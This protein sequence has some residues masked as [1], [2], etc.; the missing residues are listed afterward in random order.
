MVGS[1]M[2]FG[3]ER[4]PVLVD[5]LI[6]SSYNKDKKGL[7]MNTTITLKV[8]DQTRE[9]ILRLVSLRNKPIEEL[10]SDII[11]E[12]YE[13]EFVPILYADRR[14]FWKQVDKSGGPDA[15]WPWLGCTNHQD[16]NGYGVGRYQKKTNHSHRI[17]YLLETGKILNR[18]TVIRHKC[19]NKLCCNPK[20]LEEGTH[21]DN[22]ADWQTRLIDQKGE[23]N[24]YAKLT[25]KQVSKI[26]QDAFEGKTLKSIADNL[27]VS[28]GTVSLIVSGRTWQ[29][30]YDPALK[31]PFKTGNRNGVYKKFTDEQIRIIRSDF[32]NKIA[33]MG[34]LAKEYKVTRGVINRI[35]RRE[36][37]REVL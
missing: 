7:N 36:T 10:L 23:H 18:M 27:G 2:Q 26:R 11:C 25:E 24:F 21:A 35:I 19:D 4:M 12:K 32:E 15:C 30:S 20:H 5:C 37:Y 8:D 28:G 1:M 9:Y 29:H 16:A 31:P 6:R 22:I 34:E 14:R 3:N 17:A 13:E 33:T